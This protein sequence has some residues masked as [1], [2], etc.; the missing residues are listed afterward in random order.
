MPVT[1]D[2]PRSEARGAPAKLLG[3][4]VTHREIILVAILALAV[5]LWWNL[6]VHPPLKFAFADMGGYLERAQ[7]SIDRAGER[8]PYFTLFPW[9]T[10]TLIALVK[11]AFGR[12][13]GAAIGAVYA[14]LAAA[15]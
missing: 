10:H 14:L 15:A 2:S 9:G 7:T 1:D 13:N 6:S 5:R 11:R 8:L 4:L 12:D 3:L